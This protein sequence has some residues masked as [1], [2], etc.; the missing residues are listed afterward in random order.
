MKFRPGLRMVV[1]MH[2]LPND[3]IE[4]LLTVEAGSRSRLVSRNVVDSTSKALRCARDFID[5]RL[6]DLTP[7]AAKNAPSEPHPDDPF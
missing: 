3:E 4:V 1:T 6:E 2:G 5:A 7:A